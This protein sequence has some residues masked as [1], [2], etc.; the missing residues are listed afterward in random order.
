MSEQLIERI[1]FLGLILVLVICMISNSVLA[2]IGAPQEHD[3]EHPK[4]KKCQKKVVGQAIIGITMSTCSYGVLYM[5]LEDVIE[6]TPK[7][8]FFICM[9]AFLVM[10][11]CWGISWF[12]VYKAIISPDEFFSE[13]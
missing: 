6:T 4:R 9:G 10:L 3:P 8:R 1:P 11:V 12:R 2:A 13:N 5:L 7:T